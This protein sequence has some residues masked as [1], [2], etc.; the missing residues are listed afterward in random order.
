MRRLCGLLFML[1]VVS[2]L[3]DGQDHRSYG[4]PGRQAMRINPRTNGKTF[5]LIAGSGSDVLDV[6][7]RLDGALEDG[8]CPMVT[9][10]INWGLYDSASANYCSQDAQCQGAIN[11]AN[12]VQ[13]IRQTNPASAIVLLGF[14]RRPGR[15]AG[16][17]AA[18]AR[19][20]RSHYPAVAG[21]FILL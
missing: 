6:K 15:A 11:M 2:Q 3:V 16:C 17:R 13:K 12:E 18:S 9:C 5:V 1:A 4:P 14:C 21:G 8:S 20:Y 10:S 7:E 19:Q